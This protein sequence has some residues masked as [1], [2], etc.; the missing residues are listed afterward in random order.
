MTSGEMLEMIRKRAAN[1]VGEE[2]AKMIYAAITFEI[3]EV[4]PL[5]DFGQGWEKLI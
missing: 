5:V 1:L 3:S 2:A 4:R